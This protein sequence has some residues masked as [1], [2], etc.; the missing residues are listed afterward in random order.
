MGK[1]VVHKAVEDLDWEIHLCG[2]KNYQDRGLIYKKGW[3]CCEEHWRNVT[4]KKCIS[5]KEKK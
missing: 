1:K 2:N 4:C 5:K 3:S